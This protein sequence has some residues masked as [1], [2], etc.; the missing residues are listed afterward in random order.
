MKS[1]YIH[2]LK[3]ACVLLAF[4]AGGAIANP[5]ITG[6]VPVSASPYIGASNASTNTIYIGHQ[7]IHQPD[8]CAAGKQDLGN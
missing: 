2:T 7:C 5:S 4:L 1:T 3:F 8:P 6:Q